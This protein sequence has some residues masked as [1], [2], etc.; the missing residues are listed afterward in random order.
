MDYHNVE[1]QK[2]LEERWLDVKKAELKGL[3][4]GIG[5]TAKSVLKPLVGG[6]V[7]QLNKQ[8]IS[9]SVQQTKFDSLFNHFKNVFSKKL[10]DIESSLHNLRNYYKNDFQKDFKQLKIT[11]PVINEKFKKLHN[12]M[13]EL[14]SIDSK[15][16]SIRNIIEIQ[17]QVL[18]AVEPK[19]E[20][21][22]EVAPKPKVISM[23]KRITL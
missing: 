14:N 19:K 20:V 2:I 10:N 22:P 16:S 15:I 1:D 23:P 5:Q 13:N 4:K 9:K 18:K 8:D 3:G 6:D 12:F 11:D 21:T 7:S 17:P